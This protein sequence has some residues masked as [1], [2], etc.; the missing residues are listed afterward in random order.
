MIKVIRRNSK[1]LGEIFR[2]AV[3][4]TA[5][6]LDNNF[7]RREVKGEC[8]DPGNWDNKVTPQEY[9][10]KKFAQ[11]NFTKLYQRD[12]GRYTLH[13]HSNLWY[14]FEVTDCEVK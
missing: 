9:L 3:D 11:F 4:I 6:S 10:A 7:I 14:E 2:R 12:D 1:E 8:I 5:F 13:I